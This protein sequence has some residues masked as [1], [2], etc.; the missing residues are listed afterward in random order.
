MLSTYASYQ[1]IARDL[2]AA[3]ERVEKNPI[4]D[5][6]TD[7]YLENITKVKSIEEFVNN[8]RLFRYAM[9]AHGLEDMTYAKAFMIKALKEGITSQDSF[10]NKL[11]DKRYAEFVATY[12]FARYGEN[13]TSYNRAQMDVPSN[14]RTQVSLSAVEPGFAFL[15]N[16]VG[17][18][19]SNIE[20]VTSIDDLMGDTRLLTFAMAAFGLDATTEPPATVRQMLEGGVTDPNSPANSLADKRYAN[21]VTAF[22]FV[23]HGA[24]TTS[25]DEVLVDL[26]KKAVS[27]TGLQLVRPR[28]DYIES[29]AEYF[30]ENISK[31]KTVAAFMANDR[32]LTFA[33]AAH[34]LDISVENREEIRHF[35]ESGVRDPMS[36]ANQ[37]PDKRY[38]SF[39]AA[40]DFEQY[41][42]LATS[43]DSALVDAPELWT[44]KTKLGL[45]MPSDAYVKAETDYY[46]ANVVKLDSIDDLMADKRLLEYAL[47]SYGLDPEKESPA[48]I[49]KM[50]E[51]GVTD[52]NSP[53]NKLTDKRY[54]GFVA[55]FNFAQYGED[56][57]RHASAL[58]PAADKF[59]RQTLEQNAG[60][61]NEGVRLALYFERKAST[62]TD[63]Y[64]VLADP[65]LAAVVR[66]A[67]SLPDSFSSADIDR[68]VKFF[69]E[70][71]NI[72][73]FSDPEKLGKFL[74]RFTSMYELKN[75]TQS[76]QA[77]VSVLFS[78]PAEYGVST[79]LL[80]T[81]QR[82]RLGG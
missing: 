54:A 72:E 3:L 35:I 71:L 62:I 42:N 1:L 29:E 63:F 36:L 57:T 41:G 45:I 24:A 27:D 22:N 56:A 74:Q 18:Y 73:D 76:P 50:L 14:F 34:G 9:K 58:Q 60:E 28:A 6:D 61:D 79:D 32:L 7:Y 23:E 12:N 37:H 43:Q 82:L 26:P 69:E 16:E 30:K 78:Q 55:A 25:R 2:P 77:M 64:Q 31:I 47:W 10:A 33:M 48:T 70:K 19:L 38:A 13:A 15:G 17:Y 40:F 67:L 51:G 49:R 59:I 66:T 75:P 65:A 44:A 81:M 68:Q 46:L 20:N 21:F 39:V 53:A 5:R 8:D 80:L 4:V 52:P 11:T